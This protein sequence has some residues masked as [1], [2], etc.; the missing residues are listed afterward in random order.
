MPF[1]GPE[2]D[3]DQEA[4][5]ER[6]RKREMQEWDEQLDREQFDRTGEWDKYNREIEDWKPGTPMPP[7]PPLDDPWRGLEVGN[8]PMPKWAGPPD[9]FPG[10]P[11]PDRSLGVP[12]EAMDPKNFPLQRILESQYPGPPPPH[13]PQGPAQ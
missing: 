11:H 2:P 6:E 13:S 7:I 8:V 12:R 4:R 3:I 10:A 5:A 1:R 9:L